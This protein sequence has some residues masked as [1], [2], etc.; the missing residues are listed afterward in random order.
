M[1]VRAATD[2]H[3]AMIH[4]PLVTVCPRQMQHRATA[5][6]DLVASEFEDGLLFVLVSELLDLLWYL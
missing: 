6:L 4:P 1:R 2:G 3:R 5:V